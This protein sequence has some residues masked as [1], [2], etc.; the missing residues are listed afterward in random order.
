MR[1]GRWERSTSGHEEAHAAVL[2]R[3]RL[4]T[5]WNLNEGAV[6]ACADEAYGR[7]RSGCAKR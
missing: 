6:A 4:L 3:F 2:L 7:Q 5:V 1:S